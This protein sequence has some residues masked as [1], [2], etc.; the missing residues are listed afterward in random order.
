[1]AA[2][3]IQKAAHPDANIIWGMAFDDTLDDEMVVTVV[4]TGFDEN[5]GGIPGS[6]PMSF[7]S[8]DDDDDSGFGDIMHLFGSKH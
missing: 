1:M 4:A 6:T 3:T 5:A 2:T 8:A 7:A